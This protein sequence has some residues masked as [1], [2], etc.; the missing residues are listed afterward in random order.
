MP[1]FCANLSLLFTELPF[2]ERFAA[3]KEAGFDWVEVLFPYDY[4]GQEMRSALIQHDLKMALINTPPPNWAGG[5]RGYGAIPNR[6][7]RFQY[8]FRRTLRYATLLKAR[9]IHIMAGRAKGA[10]ARAT[11]VRNLKWACAQAPKQSLTIEPINQTDMPGY[12]LHDFDQAAEIIDEVGAQNLSLQFDAYHAHMI[13][14]DVPAL[15]KRHGKLVGH[16]QIA[17]APGRHEPIRGEIDYP[18]FFRTLDQAGYEGVVSAEYHPAGSTQDGL[19]WLQ[20]G[21]G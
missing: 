6:E 11:F 21:A 5:E 20:G 14:G 8:D 3:A 15:W 7:K 9:H 1:R 17:G 13:I 4:P 12:F 19:D 18:A 10:V 16:I 2:L